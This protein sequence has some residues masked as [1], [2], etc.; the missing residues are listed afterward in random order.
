MALLGALAP[1]AASRL[2]PHVLF[3]FGPSDHTY[4]RGFEPEWEIDP[5]GLA[6]H[7][8]S[9][10]ARVLLPAARPSVITGAMLG[11]GRVI[12][13][14]AIIVLLL[15]ATL[16]FNGV[17]E[18]PLLGTL[19]GTGSTLMAPEDLQMLGAA[20]ASG[21]RDQVLRAM[22]EINLSPIFRAEASNYDGFHEM[23]TALRAPTPASS[24]NTSAISSE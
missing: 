1:V 13:D 3:N 18:V 15:G 7:W 11:V 23:A 17:G 22:W 24:P 6:T 8:S 2:N 12:G 5:D 14:T 20:M 21:D 9:H 19:R 16:R 10:S 4:L